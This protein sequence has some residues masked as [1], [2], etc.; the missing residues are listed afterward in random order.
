MKRQP[1]ITRSLLLKAASEL[2][3]ETGNVLFSTYFP[4]LNALNLLD[5]KH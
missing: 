3:G 1:A 4:Q 5:N 2:A